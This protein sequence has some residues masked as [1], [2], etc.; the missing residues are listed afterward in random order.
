[1]SLVIDGITL[2]EFP[3]GLFDDEYKYGIIFISHIDETYTF[4]SMSSPVEFV[5]IPGALIGMSGDYATSMATMRGSEY[6]ESSDSW[7][8]ISIGEMP[9]IPL[10][11]G[12]SLGW[13]N[14]DIKTVIAINEDTFELTTGDEIYFPNSET[15]AEPEPEYGKIRRAIIRDASNAVRRKTGRTDKFPPEQL[16]YEI[17]SIVTADNALVL[18]DNERIYQFVVVTDTIRASELVKSN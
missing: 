16:E 5:H 18:K 11:D 10:G 13:S 9:T 12:F 17:D 8:T 2:P 15:P 7:T 6:L 14:H 4:I 3:E 1:M